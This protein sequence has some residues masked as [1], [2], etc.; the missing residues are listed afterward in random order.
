MKGHI[1]TWLV[2]MR[3]PRRLWR[4]LGCV[5]FFAIHVILGLPILAALVNP[6]LWLLTM[7]WL[8]A[9]PPWV[10]AI[11]P[12]VTTALGFGAGFACYLTTVATLVAAARARGISH[13]APAA[14]TVPAYWMLMTIAVYKGLIQLLRPSRRH[15]W[16]LT[17][18]GLVDG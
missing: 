11:F 4:E 1:Q 5:R 8:L 16:E 3:S 7:I 15:H 14:I 18:H 10:T 6:F 13:V 2:H 12:P 17:R 9:A